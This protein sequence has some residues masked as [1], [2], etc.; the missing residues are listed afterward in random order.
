MFE[1]LAG[2]L[3]WGRVEAA[4]ARPYTGYYRTISAKAAA[5]VESLAQNHGFA[6]GNKRTALSLALLLLNRS[7]YRLVTTPPGN[8]EAEAVAM[9]RAAAKGTMRFVELESWF[10]QRIRRILVEK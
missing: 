3:N 2:I 4:V 7:G 8:E 9:V 1:G 10:R 6:D 5:L